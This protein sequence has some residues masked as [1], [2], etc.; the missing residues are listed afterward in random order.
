MTA[1]FARFQE[2]VARGYITQSIIFS[3]GSMEVYLVLTRA[4]NIVLT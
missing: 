3:V 2:F 1:D 4:V